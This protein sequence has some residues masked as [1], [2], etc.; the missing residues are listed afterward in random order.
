MARGSPAADVGLRG[1]RQEV[2]VF[3]TYRLGAGGDLIVAIDGKPPDS[4]DSLRRALDRKRAGDTLELTIY[5]DGRTQKVKVTL[6][7]APQ[8]L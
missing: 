1:M 7:E 8:T 2:I 4:N 5:R 6:G 3:G